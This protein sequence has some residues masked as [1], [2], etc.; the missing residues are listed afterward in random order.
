MHNKTYLNEWNRSRKNN[1]RKRNTNLIHHQ[2]TNSKR[3]CSTN[4]NNRFNTGIIIIILTNNSNHNNN[5]IM[6]IIN[7]S[8][9]NISKNNNITLKHKIKLFSHKVSF[10]LLPFLTIIENSFVYK[11]ERKLKLRN[12]FPIFNMIL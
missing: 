4:N 3:G 5:T 6:I 8:S 9:I 1:R 7:R 2:I 10:Q 12:S 11:K